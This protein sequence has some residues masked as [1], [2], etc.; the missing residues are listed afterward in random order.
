MLWY[1]YS[2]YWECSPQNLKRL[3]SLL[4]ALE[5]FLYLL[6]ILHVCVSKHLETYWK[7]LE[8]LRRLSALPVLISKQNSAQ[9]S[10]RTTHDICKITIYHGLDFMGAGTQGVLDPLSE[11]EKWLPG[12]GETCHF[13]F[14]IFHHPPQ[15]C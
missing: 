2:Q 4:A 9:I 15:K 6:S 10:S 5:L 12:P 8:L 14:T 11:G 13:Y 7:C 1:G 3:C